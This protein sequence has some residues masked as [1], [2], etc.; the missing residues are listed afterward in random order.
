MCPTEVRMLKSY[1]S[2]WWYMEVVSLIRIR[3]GHEGHLEK[4]IHSS[5]LAWQIPWTE[6]PGGLQSVG[7]Q[8]VWHDWGINTHTHTHTH[9]GCTLMN[10]ISLLTGVTGAL[11]S[12]LC[13]LSWGYDEKPTVYSPEEGLHQNPTTL[14]PWFQTSTDLQNCENYISII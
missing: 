10:G 14:V 11:A 7:L 5:I 9:E 2:M 6:K 12:S 3:W 1:P 4:A 8:R 13:C